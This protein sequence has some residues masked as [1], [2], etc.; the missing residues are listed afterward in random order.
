MYRFSIPHLCIINNKDKIMKVFVTGAT[1]FVGSAV[2]QELINAGHEVLGLARS[3]ASAALLVAAGAQVHKGDLEDLE[4]L[5]AGAA[6]TDGIIHTGFIHDFSNYKEM[7]EVDKRAIE[8]MGEA[9]VGTNKPLIVTSGTALVK[10]GQLATENDASAADTPNPRLTEQA[11]DAV[12]ARGVHVSV[13]RLP[14]SVHGEGDHGFVP[15][16]I[17]I[18]R[19]KGVSVYI[20]DGDSVWPAVHRTDAAK[21]FRLAL[22]RNAEGVTRYHAVAESG[23]R[24]KEIAEVIGRRLN[25]PVESKSAKDAAVHFD[26]FAHFASLNNPTSS[27]LTQE[28]LNWTYSGIGLKE[29]IDSDYYFT[30]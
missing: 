13:V 10:Q 29:D 11:A 27:Q 23:I 22:E 9:L 6:Q 19:R 18:A 2:V 15:I 4:S 1:G 16:L 20:E 25:L 14:P 7:C 5:K 26:W 30:V 8:A 28:Q 12:A 17:D 21:V 24:F 3:D